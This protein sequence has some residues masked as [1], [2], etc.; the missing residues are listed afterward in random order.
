MTT[1]KKDRLS[2][3]QE[4]KITPLKI[5]CEFF[6]DPEK[7]LIDEGFREKLF[8][9]TF[10]IDSQY[11]RLPTAKLIIERKSINPYYRYLNIMW[12]D[13]FVRD[14]FWMLKPYWDRVLELSLIYNTAWYENENVNLRDGKNKNNLLSLQFQAPVLQD[15]Q[16]DPL[17]KYSPPVILIMNDSKKLKQDL[18]K[19]IKPAIRY[20]IK[21]ENQDQQKNI[22]KKLGGKGKI[23][24]TDFLIIQ[25][26][27]LVRSE[28]SLIRCKVGTH[29]TGNPKIGVNLNVL[30][31]YDK[32]R[33]VLLRTIDGFDFKFVRRCPQCFLFFVSGSMRQITCGRSKCKNNH[34]KAKKILFTEQ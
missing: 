26:D 23:N 15:S 10:K 11:W 13:K 28:S 5:I 4:R 31:A 3:Q 1:N 25:R 19:N 14:V 29:R 24:R 6:N 32:G 18:K 2:S 12:A 20:Y 21:P 17:K 16:N 34:F 8:G 22:I 27:R 30:K 33:D 9:K 7:T